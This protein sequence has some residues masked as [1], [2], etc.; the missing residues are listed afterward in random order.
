MKIE[1]NIN[2]LEEK[3]IVFAPLANLPKADFDQVRGFGLATLRNQSLYLRG[4]PN[5]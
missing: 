4:Y 3:R 2:G 5:H 1:F